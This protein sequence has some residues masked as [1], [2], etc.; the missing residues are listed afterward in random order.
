MG[1]LN[2]GSLR[3]AT[4]R[5]LRLRR[6]LR[7]GLG[8]V[9]RPDRWRRFLRHRRI[10]RRRRHRWLLR[11]HRRLVGARKRQFEMEGRA[12]IELALHLDIPAHQ[13]HQLL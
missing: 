12:L 8:C 6:R 5:G 7:T 13:P 1:A 9:A 11:G 4:R 3:R 2:I 10:M